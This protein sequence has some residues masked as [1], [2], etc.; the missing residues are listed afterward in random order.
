M[1]KE[2]C[3]LHYVCRKNDSV[4][5]DSSGSFSHADHVDR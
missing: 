1:K 3:I 4:M 2:E 5:W